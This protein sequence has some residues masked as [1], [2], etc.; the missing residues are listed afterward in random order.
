MSVWQVIRLCASLVI[1]AH[2]VHDP[3]PFDF[4]QE[5][6]LPALTMGVT[7]TGVDLFVLL[8]F[9]RPVRFISVVSFLPF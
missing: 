2:V 3:F 6:D 4:A 5:A 1:R 9:G 8:V 7:L